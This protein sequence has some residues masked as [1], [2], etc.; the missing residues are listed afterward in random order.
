MT[1]SPALR[2]LIID[3]LYR[4]QTPTSPTITPDGSRAVYVLQR[5]DRDS[6]SNQT[7]LCSVGPGH[8]AAPLTDGPAD[9][10]PAVSPD[11]RSVAFLRTTDGVPQLAVVSIDGDQ[12]RTIT[13]LALGA[14]SPH[15]SPDGSLIVFSAP[16][17]PEG[18]QENAPIVADR[19]NFKADGTG[20]YGARTTHV[21]AV[22][23]ATGAVR[24]LTAGD[25]HA[26]TPVVSPDGTMIAF[27][28]RAEPDADL[29]M[30]SCAYVLPLS[31]G[32]PERIGQTRFVGGPL[33]WL[34]DSDA[35]VA[36]GRADE[37][38]GNSRLIVLD[39]GGAPDRD[40]T[41]ALDRN[42]MPGGSAAYPGAAPALTPDGREIIFCLRDRGWTHAYRI[43]VTGGPAEPLLTGDQQ[44]VKGLAVAAGAAVAVAVVADDQSFGEMIFVRLGDGGRQPVTRLTM[45]SLD[46]TAPLPFEQRLFTISDGTTVHGWLLRPPGLEGPAPLLLD[47]HGGPHNAWTGVA[48]AVHLYQQVLAGRGWN[49]LILN[50][51]GSDGY[52]E[53][54]MRA[55]VGGWGAADRA[56]FI[57]PI[58]QLIAEG[59][60]DP[61]RVA[62]TGYS[63]GGFTTCYLTA[64]TDRFAAAIAGGVVCDLN[65]QLGASDLGLELTSVFGGADPVTD[66]EKLIAASPI[67]SVGKVTAPTLLLHGAEDHRC[68]VNQGERWFG[69][70]RAQRVPTSLV[71]YPGG[72]HGFVISGPP[73]H[74]SDYNHRV[75]DW[76]DRYMPELP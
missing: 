23:V 71:I 69:A 70:L 68:P 2:P 3:D 37:Q 57:E 39:L 63:Y 5:S 42:V 21:H 41:A 14:G 74:R 73:S 29:E 34:A 43:P 16:V 8:P 66:Q 22:E 59:L 35:V 54:F 49:V 32:E 38:I 45:E 47:V 56:D 61:D 46:G 58:D 26:G 72:A 53:D 6:D 40:L 55:V 44:V 1:D 15:W 11:G 33:L 31:G 9:S 13:D 30:T 25:W 64:H 20:R 51:R 17:E 12:V 18:R 52:G 19:L 4:I 60:V 36:V 75:V 28:A 24:R 7:L 65:A 10:S 76:L 27:T 50:P 67:G 62:I 48:D